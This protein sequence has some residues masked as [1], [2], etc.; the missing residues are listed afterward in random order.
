MKKQSAI[1]S[2]CD[3]T[4]NAYP[5]PHELLVERH[6]V[7]LGGGHLRE[8]G[9][10]GF[11]QIEEAY[12]WHVSNQLMKIVRAQ[13]QSMT[14]RVLKVKNSRPL[15]ATVVLSTGELNDYKRNLYFNPSRKSENWYRPG[16]RR[17]KR[18]LYEGGIGG[19]R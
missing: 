4:L 3:K 6:L 11:D 1:R 5:S 10:E 15:M 16:R 12:C 17:E 19:R 13:H 9:R 18:K 2:P 7:G 8:E 14:G